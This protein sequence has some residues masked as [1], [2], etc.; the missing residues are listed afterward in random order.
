[1]DRAKMPARGSQSMAGGAAAAAAPGRLPSGAPGAQPGTPQIVFAPDSFWLAQKVGLLA[2]CVWLASAGTDDVSWQLFGGQLRVALVSLIVLGPMFVFSG[3]TLRGLSFHTGRFWLA[4]LVFALLASVFGMWRRESLTMIA[5]YCSKGYIIF[6]IICA[7]AD[8]YDQCRRLLYAKI[9]GALPVLFACL[10]LGGTTTDGRFIIPNSYLFNNANDLALDLLFSAGFF[11]YLALRRS[12][13]TRIL[14]A[15]GMVFC[16]VFVVRTAS[17]GGVIALLLFL[18]ALV[19]FS[20]NRLVWMLLSVPIL[21]A[22][23]SLVP[24]STLRRLTT[25]YFNPQVYQI[26]S[27]DDLA[28][29]GS[30]LQRVQ[31]MKKAVHYSVVHPLLGVGPGQFM[32]AVWDEEHRMGKYPPALGT[33]NTYLEVS[34][35]CGIPAFI[36]Y[37]FVVV[38]CITINFRT[39]RRLRQRDNMKDA[40]SMAYCLF[41]TSIG[42]AANIFFHHL[43]YSGYLPLLAGFT[44]CLSSA[45]ESVRPL[46]A[47]VAAP[48]RLA[49]APHRPL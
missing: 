35:E 46:Q 4:F 12:I 3:R 26:H 16:V 45:R 6:F 39:M 48:S 10:F 49:A 2:L 25:I 34:S 9:I 15:A 8:T 11:I 14:G 1:M 13:L 20:R 5:S 47:V 33:H 30:Q 37:T 42:F 41:V 40:A 43:A 27:N 17:R 28:S 18:A 7:F 44:V 19:L 23:F 31:L 24:A 29:I 36:C 21:I 32:N 38:A 22:G